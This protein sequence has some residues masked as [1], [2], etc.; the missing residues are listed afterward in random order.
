MTDPDLLIRIDENVKY[1]RKGFDD[2]KLAFDAHVAEDK[3]IVNE[4]LRPLWENHQQDIGASRTRGMGG[5]LI[6]FCINACIA[7]TAAWAAVKGIGK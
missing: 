4:F 3:K 7:V 2:H 1:L 6:G 5:L